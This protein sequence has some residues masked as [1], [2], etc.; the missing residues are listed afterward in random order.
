MRRARTLLTHCMVRSM[1]SQ[2]SGNSGN[3]THPVPL[4]QAN[5]FSLFDMLRNVWEWTSDNYE[6]GHRVLRGGSW[7]SKSRGIRASVHD[8]SS[9]TP[10]G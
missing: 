7:Y 3:T 4:K 8:G 9:P 2:Y 10:R 5:A 6:D 1:Q